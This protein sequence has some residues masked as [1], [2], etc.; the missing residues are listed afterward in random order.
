MPPTVDERVVPQ[1]PLADEVPEG[2]AEAELAGTLVMLEGWPAGPEGEAPP[3]EA[4]TLVKLAD[5]E[6]ALGADDPLEPGALLAGQLHS[7]TVTVVITVIGEPERGAELAGA[8]GM[9]EQE[10]AGVLEAAAEETGV[11]EATAD[12]DALEP[13]PEPEHESAVSCTLLH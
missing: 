5:C 2:V 8:E 3:E 11:E 1:L 4:G 13:A 9:E 6:G 12:E 7:V 10:T